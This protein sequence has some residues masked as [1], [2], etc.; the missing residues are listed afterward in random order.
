MR[1]TGPRVST[2]LQPDRTNRESA[3]DVWLPELAAL[4]DRWRAP[5]VEVAAHGV[6]PHITLLYP[7]RPAP[8]RATD[9]AEATA[10]L[11]GTPPFTVTLRQLGRFPGVLYLRPEPDD[12]LRGI[13]RRLVAAFP[14]TPPYGGRFPDPAPHLTVA[15]GATEAEL[16]RLEAV[17][18][19]H[20]GPHLPLRIAVRELAIDEEG[21]DGVWYV[22]ETLPLAEGA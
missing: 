15:K 10:A 16:D 5:T 8:V 1:D 14:D 19:E 21:P 18:G 20:I 13:T 6:P 17:I 4:L 9:I 22:R 3:I 7:W 11:A 12:V 2:D